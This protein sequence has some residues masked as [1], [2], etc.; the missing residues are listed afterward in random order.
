MAKTPNDNSQSPGSAQ[1]GATAPVEH[2][3]YTLIQKYY[4]RLISREALV[5]KDKDPEDLH[6]MRVAIRRLQTA[7]HIFDAAIVLPKAAQIKSLQGITK[8]LGKLRDLDVQLDTLETDYATKLDPSEHSLLQQAIA[9]LA[10][11]RKKV[12]S[13]VKA[14]LKSEPYQDLKTAY[15]GW[16][17]QPH[18]T[19]A[20]QQPLVLVLPELLSPLLSTLLLHPGWL[21][22]A[23]DPAAIASPTLHDLRKTCKHVRY[24]A[25]FFTDFY[26]PAF[27]VWIQEI[28]GLQ[29][30]LGQ[31]HDIQVLQQILI[32]S[33]PE[34]E[35]SIHLRQMIAE[36]QAAALGLWRSVQAK[37][38]SP[39]YRL[40]LHQ[41]LLSPLVAAVQVG[42][43]TLEHGTNGGM[44]TV[45][46]DR[47]AD[48]P[49]AQEAPPKTTKPRRP[50]TTTTPKSTPRTPRSRRTRPKPTTDRPPSDGTASPS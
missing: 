1:A 18:Y 6:Q 46:S 28:K 16:L 37:Y 4:H 35:E 7:L 26:A 9:V 23:D 33:V 38:L 34:W 49:V 17:A 20:A 48:T 29:D 22:E 19:P 2:Y 39:D 10:K 44:M 30:S 25:E 11:Q 24:Q 14:V 12:F 31:A 32:K 47:D 27:Q 41:L 50:A 8:R 42:T 40:F 43:A 36:Q 15:E 45:P 21:L 5:L 3:A 13:Q